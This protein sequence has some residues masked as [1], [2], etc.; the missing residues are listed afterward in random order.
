MKKTT[1]FLNQT[2]VINPLFVLLVVIGIIVFILIAQT[3][4]FKGK[5][6]DLYPKPPAEAA[7]KGGT[8]HTSKA[9]MNVSPDIVYAGG[10]QYTI[11]GH[12]FFP[13]QTV[14]LSVADPGCC[15]AFNQW[16]D[17]NGNMS[18]TRATGSAGT[19]LI[20]AYQQ[21]NNKYVLMGTV[22]FGVIMH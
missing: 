3:A 4:P 20:K 11:S 8:K 14:A 13:N 12:G 22:S 17:A 10:S 2:T 19:Y 9:I 16:A 6:E 7:G 1:A 5:Q 15:L 18:F 21:S